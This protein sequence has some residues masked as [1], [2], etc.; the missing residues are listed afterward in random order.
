MS[1]PLAE[2]INPHQAV[3]ERR[4]Y[5]GQ[6]LLERLGRLH[7]LVADDSD[8]LIHYAFQFGRDE[9]GHELVSGRV[10]GCL[11]LFCQRC[12]QPF[13]LEVD[14]KVRLALVEGLD[15]AERLPED[16]DPLLID[17]EPIRT[18][19][20]VEDEL[21]LAIPAVPRHA[22]GDCP[23]EPAW[24]RVSNRGEGEGR[25]TRPNP[26]AQLEALKTKTSNKTE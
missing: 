22:D 9:R 14:S 6:V 13:L 5:Q 8:Q 12:N 7:D 15:E 11:P 24:K 20:L 2:R 19:D 1:E 3:A 17:G 16:L 25:V 18:L 23:I 10:R 4:R 26:F 21:L